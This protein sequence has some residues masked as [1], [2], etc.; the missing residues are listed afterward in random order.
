MRPRL[1][2]NNISLWRSDYERVNGFDEQYVGW[3]FEDR[4]LQYRLERIGVRA[5]SVLLR[6]ALVHL[7][8]PAAPTFARNGVGTANLHYF[9]SIAGRPTFCVDGLTKPCGNSSIVPFR[10]APAAVAAS[11]AA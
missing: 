10:Q 2:G 9:K 4:D 11:R 8:H 1:T 7:W 5:S 6:T 3:G